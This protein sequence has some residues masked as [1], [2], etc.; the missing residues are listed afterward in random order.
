MSPEWSLTNAEYHQPAKY[1]T[2]NLLSIHPHQATGHF[3][4]GGPVFI[5]SVDLIRLKYK[6]IMSGPG[7]DAR[8][9]EWLSIYLTCL[10][11]WVP[12]PMAQKYSK[13]EKEIPKESPNNGIQMYILQS[14]VK[15]SFHSIPKFEVGEGRQ[16]HNI[17]LHLFS[18]QRINRR[19]SCKSQSSELQTINSSSVSQ[20]S[21]YCVTHSN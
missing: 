5:L 18:K 16:K 7:G 21:A 10:K 12:S 15:V 2:T 20:D 11:P 3:R 4:K 14:N 19:T 6:V 17:Y 8:L 13:T 9:A 1:C